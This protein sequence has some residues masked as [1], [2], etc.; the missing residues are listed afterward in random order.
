MGANCDFECFKFMIETAD[1]EYGPGGWP[2][3]QR[4]TT[5]LGGRNVFDEEGKIVI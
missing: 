2:D 1:G 4:D 5:A 3:I